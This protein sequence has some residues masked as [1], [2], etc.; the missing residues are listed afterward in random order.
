MSTL[1]LTL[2]SVIGFSGAVHSGLVLHPDDRHVLYPLGSTIVVKDLITGT[3]RFLQH[4]H[5]KPV[6]ALRLEAS[7]KWLATGQVTHPGFQAPII[8]WDLDTLEVKYR[9]LL[10]KGNIQD[11]AFSEDGRYLAS[12]GQEDN[13]LVLWSLETGEPLCGTT[14]ANDAVYCVKFFNKDSTKIVTGGN[15]N[16][17]VWDFDLANRKVRPTDCNWGAQKRI[18]NCISVDAQDEFIYCGTA[19]GDILQVSCGPKLLRDSGPKKKPLSLGVQVLNILANGDFLVGAGDGTVA[20]LEKGT[21]K[22]IRSLK[23]DGGITSVV[24]NAK[25]DHFFVGTSQSNIYCVA[26]ANFDHETRSTCHCAP[27]NCVAFPFG[28]SELVATASRSDIRIWN[29]R[30][31]VDLLRIQVPN[32]ECHCVAFTK[33]GKSILSGW[34]DGKIRAFKPQSGALMFTINDAHT[35]GAVTALVASNDSSKLVSGG[36][37]GRVRIWSINKNTQSLLVSLKEH[38]GAIASISIKDDDS[39]CV[40]ASADGSCI[41]WDLSRFVR[42]GCLFASTQFSSAVYLPDESQILTTGTDRKI[43]YWDAQDYNAIRIVDGSDAG[44]INSLSISPDGVMFASAGADRL[45]KLWHYDEGVVKY[46]GAGH[47]GVVKM[48]KISPDK[49]TIVSVGAE[50]SIFFWTYPDAQ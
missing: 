9:L 40:S 35:P 16:L 43:T 24:L 39:E 17:R 37:D 48:V 10:H 23:L 30:S 8:V 21:F 28:Y 50:G 20:L 4:G 18:V 27:I 7:G 44:E 13:K 6:A 34:S 2:T 36:Q 46:V 11:V 41:S 15:L 31:K 22:E 47:S 1:P 26:L 38:K 25:R 29:T 5:D 3:Q 42:S 33:D 19:S 14:A 12:I 45:I 49:K 32:L